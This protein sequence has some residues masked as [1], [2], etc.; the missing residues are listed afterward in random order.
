[1][2]NVDERVVIYVTSWLAN[3]Y[4]VPTN[5]MANHA[6]TWSSRFKY[7]STYLVLAGNAIID[8]TPVI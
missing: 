3:Y 7:V 1:M 4:D 5:I 2:Y 6:V 8:T